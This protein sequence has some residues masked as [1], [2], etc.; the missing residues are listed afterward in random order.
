MTS[1]ILPNAASVHVGPISFT[2][3][4]LLWYFT[5]SLRLRA[6]VRSFNF[7]KLN[8]IVHFL[9]LIYLGS[10]ECYAY[11]HINT[12]SLVHNWNLT[13]FIVSHMYITYEHHSYYW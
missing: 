11:V 3:R 7:Q 8:F 6:H 2:T 5:Y 1:L 4:N 10:K 9:V 12:N 13:P